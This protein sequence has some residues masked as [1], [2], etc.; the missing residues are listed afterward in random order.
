MT[1][2][3]NTL[4]EPEYALTK[5]EIKYKIFFDIN[6]MEK[7]NTLRLKIR[8]NDNYCISSKER[9]P[10]TLCMCKEF[11][12]MDKE[13][14]LCKCGL[15][16]KKARTEAEIKKFIT[17]KKVFISKKEK[18]IENEKENFMDTNVENEVIEEESQE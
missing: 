11:L 13:D 4:K 14:V 9:N 5:G 15:F 6:N 3:K 1:K 18:S 12:L 8:E 7:V 16:F 17:A 2:A 10:N